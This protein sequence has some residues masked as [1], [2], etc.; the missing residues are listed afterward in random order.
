MIVTCKPATC[1]PATCKPAACASARRLF[2]SSPHLIIIPFYGCAE[3]ATDLPGVAGRAGG[4]DEYEECITVAI[5]PQFDDAL[6]ITAGVAFVPEFLAAATPK[7]G[8]ADLKSAAQALGVHPCHHQHLPRGRV[9]HNRGDQPGVVKFE[10]GE[11]IVVGHK[12]R[13]LD[14]CKEQKHNSHQQHPVNHP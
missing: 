14:G 8:L 11:E 9:L 4:I 2:A 5:D 6:G 10:E 3:E 12:D 1:K 13:F 7:D